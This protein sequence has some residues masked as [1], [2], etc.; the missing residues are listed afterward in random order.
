M[1]LRLRLVLSL[2]AL[3]AAATTVASGMAYWS[4]KSRLYEEVDRSIERLKS[5]CSLER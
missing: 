5:R 3:A 2:A 4:T 1:S